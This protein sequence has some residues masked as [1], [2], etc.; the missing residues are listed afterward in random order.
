MT[1]LATTQ[2][3]AT[4]RDNVRRLVAERFN[5]N[6][7]RFAEAI[8]RAQC[9]VNGW[10]S[11][12]NGLGAGSARNI[13]LQLNLAPGALDYPNMEL[14]D[15]ETV[16]GVSGCRERLTAALDNLKTVENALPS[17]DYTNQGHLLEAR[18]LITQALSQLQA[19]T[20]KSAK[21]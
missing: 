19:S 10:C 17:E 6:Q 12:E 13:E 2:T 7:S 5:G 20:G 8:D 9:Q 21:T 18:T 11:R 1:Q 16:T 15:R 14:P 4:R 3:N